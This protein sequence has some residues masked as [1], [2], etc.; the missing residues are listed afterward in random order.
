MNFLY[1]LIISSFVNHSKIK[2]IH[3]IDNEK[4]EKKEI[5]FD[6]IE[7]NN[8]YFNKIIYINE[9]KGIFCISNDLIK[10]IEFN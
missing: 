9:N 10:Y 1:L 2:I 8:Y 4:E 3:L 5:F 6:S 7:I